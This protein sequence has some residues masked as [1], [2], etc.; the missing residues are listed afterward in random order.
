MLLDQFTSAPVG[1]LA[2]SAALSV[3]TGGVADAILI[4]G[5]LAA[6]GV[7]GFFTE[8][9]AERTI[10]A[11]GTTSVLTTTVLRNGMR[12]EVP[13]EELVAGDVVVLSPG[14]YVPADVR[15]LEARHLTIDESTLTG[16]SM[17]VSKRPDGPCREATALA[18]RTTM[19]YMGTLVTGGSGRGV[20]VATGPRTELGTIHALVGTARPPETPLQ[21]HLDTMST[22][23]VLVGAGVCATVFG[24]GVLHGFGVVEMLLV[25]TSLAVAAV[26]EG[27][28]TV[29]TTTLALGIQDMRRK[30]VLIRRLDAVEN[31]GAIEVLCLD[32][33][34]TLTRNEMEVTAVHTA[35]THLEVSRD[36]GWSAGGAV[37]PRRVAHLQQLLEVAVLCNESEV[38]GENGSIALSGSATENALLRVAMDAGID[39]GAIRGQHPLVD[40]RY[41]TEKFRFMATLHGN[42]GTQL[43]AVKGSPA[44]VLA[45]CRWQ[46]AAGGVTELTEDARAAILQ[47]NERMAGR[48]LRVLGLAHAEGSSATALGSG[49]LTWLG[50]VGM[51]DPLRP[52]MV[53]LIERL[54]RAGIDTVMITGDQSATAYAVGRQLHLANGQPLEILDSESLAQ[55]DPQLLSGLAQRVRVFAR[56]SPAHKLEIVRALQGAG[57][58]VAMTGDGVN[59]GPAL[60]AADI[61]LVVG[62]ASTE[63]ARSVA[64]VVLEGDDLHSTLLA[65]RQGRTI[66]DNVRK[67]VHFLVATNLSEIEV[68]FGAVAFGAASPLGAAQLL[69]INLVSDVVPGIALALEPP[70]PDVLDRPPRDPHAPILDRRE[71]KRMAVESGAMAGGALASYAWGLAR[72]GPGAQASTCAFMSL[73]MAQLLH[74]VSCRS[75]ERSLLDGPPPAPNPHLTAGL[76]LCFGLQALAVVLP[77]LRALLG[78][79]PIGLLD[80]L[81]IGA[82]ATAPFLINEATKPRRREVD[83]PALTNCTRLVDRREAL[84]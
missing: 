59:D 65:V 62:D 17:P 44:E 14:D 23:L 84:A 21:R 45:M 5:V 13:A 81:V 71:W 27:L 20:V 3:L 24:M 75:P 67:A 72:Y 69:W 38:R 8:Q 29:A 51:T 64:D 2:A 41:R 54:H 68:V 16:E 56:V 52:G 18:D 77:P 61:G 12:Q 43:L 48:A 40:V 47:A 74:A 76:T 55:L 63:L 30:R 7:I 57:K 66:R 6:N 58:V 39:V 25:S 79:A 35:G 36:T 46:V 37:E 73:T 83:G 19:A 82:G 42:N 26:P 34:G 4:A 49:Q 60:R 28:P 70:E 80:A 1:V 11:L 9:H 15:V 22:E 78:I 53:E 31:L 33:T 10:D 50:L 32:K